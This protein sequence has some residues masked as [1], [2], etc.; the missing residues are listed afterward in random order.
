MLA[1]DEEL[2]K[3]RAL[4]GR[5]EGYS[6]SEIKEGTPRLIKWLKGSIQEIEE[7]KAGRD[8]SRAWEASQTE[9]A[10]L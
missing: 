4:L 5:L 10:R 7:K 6:E 2:T 3:H 1:N 8:L 9:S